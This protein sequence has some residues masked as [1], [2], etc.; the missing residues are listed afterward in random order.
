ME[1]IKTVFLLTLL[2]VLFVFIGYS[3]GGSNGM[4]IAFLLA[5][6]MNFYAYYYSDKQV[7][8]HYNATPIEDSSHPV[9]RITQKLVQKANLPMPKVYLIPDHTPN[10]FATG[11]NHENAAVAVTMGLYE[12]LNEE[13]LEGVIAHELSH[14]KHYDILIGTIAAVF[15]GAIAMIANM[16]QFGAMFGGNNRQGAHPIVMIIMAIILPLAASIIQMTVSRSREYMADEGAARMTKNP[17]GLQS[18][19]AKLENY[20]R[21]G[22]EIHNATEQT[23]HMFIVNPFS[24]KKTSFG[25]FF[26]THPTTEDRIARLEELKYEIQ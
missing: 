1:Q 25:D 15:A 3:F 10:A 12:M 6:G 7:L 18:A 26:R 8:K 17:A 19:L 13:E 9:Y 2:T 16:M 22:H 5:G 11:R 4:L 20:A 14:I 21:R 23:A 24:G